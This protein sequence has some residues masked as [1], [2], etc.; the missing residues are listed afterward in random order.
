[1][2]FPS[3]AIRF[4]SRTTALRGAF[5]PGAPAGGPPLQDFP[6]RLYRQ[7]KSGAFLLGKLRFGDYP[8]FRPPRTAA[9]GRISQPARFGNA[10]SVFARRAERR[11][12]ARRTGTRSV[13]LRLRLSRAQRFR[14][15]RVASPGVWNGAMREFLLPYDSVRTSA[16]PDRTALDFFEATYEAAANLGRWIARPSSAAQAKAR[17]PAGSRS[18]NVCRRLRC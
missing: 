9:S 18:R 2:R 13:V 5:L 1:M 12:L 14:G 4:T 10:G 17:T 3:R 11:V 7:S 6:C 8:L 16:D 15:C